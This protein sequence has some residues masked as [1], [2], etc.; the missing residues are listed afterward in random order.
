MHPVGV[1]QG[2]QL[3]RQGIAIDNGVFLREENAEVLYAH[4]GKHIHGLL[5]DR[6]TADDQRT[7]MSAVELPD[8]RAAALPQ[9]AVAMD[10]RVVQVMFVGHAGFPQYFIR[11]LARSMEFALYRL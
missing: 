1:R 2:A 11:G 7:H 8:P 4:L 5:A 3:R 10:E 9:L 6:A